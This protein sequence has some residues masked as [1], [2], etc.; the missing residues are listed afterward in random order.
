MRWDPSTLLHE[1]AHPI[2]QRGPTRPPELIRAGNA[3][4]E[5]VSIDS[6]NLPVAALFVPIVARRNGHEFAA[7]A[8][9]AGAVA[10]LIGRG[11]EGFIPSIPN[12]PRVSLI[13]VDDT[14]EAL[15]R[16]AAAQSEPRHPRICITGSNGKT[17]TRSLLG[18]ILG[19]KFA[20]LQQT[21]GNLNNHLGVPLTLLSGPENPDA[22][23][24]EFGMSALGENDRLAAIFNP[25]IA[26][27]SSIALE[28][29]EQMG[30]LANIAA[31]EA[32]PLAHLPEDALAVIPYG[33]ALLEAEV[34]R[35]QKTKG[36]RVQR[37]G[38]EREAPVRV[39]LLGIDHQSRGVIHFPDQRSQAITLDIV[40]RHNLLN[41][42][43]AMVVGREVGLDL[44][45]MATA[46][47]EVQ[48]V[49]DRG[50]RIP[51][52]QHFLIAD[53]Y[54]ANPGSMEASLHS[55]ALMGASGE[56]SPSQIQPQAQPP[57]QLEVQPQAQPPA[58]PEDPAPS[59]SRARKIAVLGDMLELGSQTEALHREL[60]TLAAQVGIDALFGYGESMR[61]ALQQAASLALPAQALEP[62]PKLAAMM[63]REY[64]EQDP[65]PA[66]VLF[67][68][69][70]G[71]YLERV[72]EALV[73]MA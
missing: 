3:A 60:G 71:V 31:A 58:Q 7:G 47:R 65:S 15:Q 18:A 49:G 50:R 55:L 56:G 37:V 48:S 29:L 9:S 70:R 46:L 14:T 54:N 51:W 72:L 61:D 21:R 19:R 45:E 32:E 68:A 63:L 17:T 34:D 67:K 38:F 30:S 8:V 23:L 28:H 1:L 39:E 12:D 35:V 40:G 57:A 43:Y 41:A 20:R 2:A 26:I 53:C 69:S 52:R 11:H 5:S 25:N 62:D 73:E 66:F 4:I 13:L 27:I 6:R 16:L 36:L 10:V 22:R 24:L 59:A 42:A 64:L 44:E 33:E